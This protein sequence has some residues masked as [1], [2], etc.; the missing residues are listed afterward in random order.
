MVNGSLTG[1]ESVLRIGMLTVVSLPFNVSDG[2]QL[3]S[4]IK[5]KSRA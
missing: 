1:L 2:A 3:E 5:E 4:R